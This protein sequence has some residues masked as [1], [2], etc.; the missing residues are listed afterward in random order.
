MIGL[1]LTCTLDASVAV[2][3]VLD[4]EG[5]SAARSVL[6]RSQAD[7]YQFMTVPDLFFAECASVLWK[8]VRRGMFPSLA[9]RQALNRLERLR[10]IVVP[11]RGLA[12]DAL[13]IA[14]HYGCAVY[15]ACYLALSERKRIPL[16]TADRQ[17]VQ[18]LEGAP[19]AIAVLG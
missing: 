7:P 12:T 15:D 10:L 2:K 5:S 4:E 9:A 17:L 16:L 14:C 1:P 19:F 3:L 13:A 6:A 11:T 8:R 18:M